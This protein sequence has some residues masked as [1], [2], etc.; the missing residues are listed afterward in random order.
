MHLRYGTRRRKPNT[1]PR[2]TPGNRQSGLGPI[3]TYYPPT[4]FRGSSGV[5][6]VL[7]QLLLS[8]RR[9][10]SPTPPTLGQNSAPISLTGG[11]G[12]N[13]FIF[14]GFL[15]ENLENEGSLLL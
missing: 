15:E 6:E 11:G 10:P 12:C 9:L 7:P 8:S 1:E 14:E 4:P 3:I 2:G 13:F 5:F